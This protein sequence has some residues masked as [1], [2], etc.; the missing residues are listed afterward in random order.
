[1]FVYTKSSKPLFNPA[2]V[3][4]DKKLLQTHYRH[5]DEATGRRYNLA[6]FTQTGQGDSKR[7]GE[8]GLMSPPPGKHWIWS[9]EKIDDGMK[10]GMIVFSKNGVPYVKRFFEDGEGSRVG[11]IWADINPVNQVA[12][13]RLDYPTQK[14][15]SL[16][17]RIILASSNKGD[18]VADFF[19]GSGTTQ[20]VAEKLGRKWIGSD[21]GKFSIH[22]AR[23][24][25][26]AVQRQLK[27]EN[28]PYRAFEI[29]NLGKYERQYYI[30]EHIDRRLENA[31]QLEQQREQAFVDL[32][33]RAY[34]AE[35]IE[36]FRTFVARKDARL[37]A[38]GPVNMPASRPLVDEM[39]KEAVEKQITKLDLLAFDF[40]MGM[41]DAARD[42]AKAKG[43][44]L[45]LKQIPRDVFDKRAVEKNQVVF[46]DVSYI[47]VRP[48][49]KGKTL[50]VELTDFS[51]HYNQ[52]ANITLKP[53]QSKVVVRDGQVIKLS[54][55]SGSEIESQ[56]VLTQKW[57]DWVDYWSV[58]FDYESKKEIVRVKKPSREQ[59]NL[60]GETDDNKLELAEYTEEWTGSYV[61]ENEWQS[62]RTKKDRHIDFTSVAREMTP[63]KTY[64]VAIKVVDIFGNDTMK[65]I[66][67]RV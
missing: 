25:M 55:D 50:A 39:L 20:A 3:E 62:F 59:V 56:E 40:E 47:E 36:G 63:G 44:D 23:K 19:A 16:L 4:K 33:V 1:I 24:R 6:D 31:E 10:S 26:I 13:E 38:I 43:I 22:T 7:F 64:R 12:K 18:L 30:G 48:I 46:N 32:I 21:L 66:E 15:E 67:V 65:V 9:Q 37:V 27:A 29:L 61:F 41:G 34:Q 14:P 45:A 58:D 11:D 53:G 54:K 17:E 57:S 42:E 51:A 60:S 49:V 52:D 2:F 8:H 35:K 5:L 28:K